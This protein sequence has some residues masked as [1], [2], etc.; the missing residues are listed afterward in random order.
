MQRLGRRV[1]DVVAEHLATLRS[2]PVITGNLPLDI[3]R[4]LAEAAPE[5]GTDFEVLLQTLRTE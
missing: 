5:E 3:R 4:K 2:Q 1:A